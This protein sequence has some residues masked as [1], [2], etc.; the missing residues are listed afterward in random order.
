MSSTT[1]IPPTWP[2]RTTIKLPGCV[3]MTRM[4]MCGDKYMAALATIWAYNFKVWGPFV[5]LLI[6]A[7]IS[8]DYYLHWG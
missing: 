1:A 2:S 8:P 7:L 3:A 5:F 4:A 6:F